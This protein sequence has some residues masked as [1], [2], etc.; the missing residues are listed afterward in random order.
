[1][2]VTAK[3]ILVATL[4]ALV[5]VTSVAVAQEPA[6]NPDPA[7][8]PAPAPAEEPG[9][10]EVELTPETLTALVGQ[11]NTATVLVTQDDQPQTS[12]V[13]VN[14][15]FVDGPPAPP[16]TTPGGQPTRAPTYV[17][18]G[19]PTAET[20]VVPGPDGRA[21]FELNAAVPGSYRVVACPTAQ[22]GQR[23]RCDQATLA[24]E[25]SLVAVLNGGNEIAIETGERGA[26]DPDGSGIAYLAPT[27]D[28]DLCFGLVAEGIMLPAVASHVHE[29]AADV[30][31]PVVQT[32]PPPGADGISL[33]CVT[34]DA[35]SLAQTPHYVNVHNAEFP[36]GALRGQLAPLG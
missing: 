31:G 33:G 12:A 24:Y 15:E 32:L 22:S 35:S 7:Q 25:A 17:R 9:F 1:M 26:G 27:G 29:G 21:E 34:L 11:T 13:R 5:P 36:S 18:Q 14:V 19:P 30:N 8:E 10:V 23:Q 28:G 20:T 6:P 2:T 4:L 3:L 16:S